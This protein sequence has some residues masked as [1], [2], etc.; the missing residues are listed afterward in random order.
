MRNVR[1]L[2]EL[3]T[4]VA[5]PLSLIIEMKGIR[6]DQI[7]YLKSVKRHTGRKHSVTL[8]NTVQLSRIYPNRG[9]A[10]CSSSSLTCDLNG[11]DWQKPGLRHN[12]TIQVNLY[13]FNELEVA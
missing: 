2:G 8:E 9:V 5:Q 7:E 4:P 10:G 12:L 1:R 11:V 3:I 13:S 6:P